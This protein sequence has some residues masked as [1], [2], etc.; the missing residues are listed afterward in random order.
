L[1]LELVLALLSLSNS[2]AI[3]FFETVH[4]NHQLKFATMLAL[5]DQ[6]NLVNTHQTAAAAKP[7]NQSKQ[8]APKTPGKPRN[9]ENNP[10]AF[11][12]R[13]FKGNGNRQENGKPVN[14]AFM[15]PMGTR[16]SRKLGI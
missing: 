2:I 1:H 8:L 9:D 5:R 3:D 4:E 12:N 11:G 13:T 16:A 14:N 7:L 15:T 6:E 10:L